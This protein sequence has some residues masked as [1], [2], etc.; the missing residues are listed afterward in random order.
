MSRFLSEYMSEKFFFGVF[1]LAL[2]Y[3]S[4]KHSEK[5]SPAFVNRLTS[6]CVLMCH[7]AIEN[8]SNKSIV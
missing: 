1:M 4:N 2:H 8:N 5:K 7:K 6:Y 3:T